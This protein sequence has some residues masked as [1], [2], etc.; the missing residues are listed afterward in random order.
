MSLISHDIFTLLQENGFLFLADGEITT[1]NDQVIAI[2][3][4]EM[5]PSDLKETYY[6]CGFQ[7]LARGEPRGSQSEIWERILDVHG[8][9]LNLPDTFTANGC[10]YKGVE[11]ESSIAAL[12]RDDNERFIFSCNYSCYR[13]PLCYLGVRVDDR[14]ILDISINQEAP[15]I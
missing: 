12:G 15:E 10:E 5:P 8:F 14:D 9:L 11:M 4:N 1:D 3:N 6:H 7:V 2:I 13:S